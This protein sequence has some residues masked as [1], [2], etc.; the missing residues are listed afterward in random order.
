MNSWNTYV[1]EMKF[2][3]FRSSVD[4]ER[5]VLLDAGGGSVDGHVAGH[6]MVGGHREIELLKKCGAKQKDVCSRHQLSHAPVLPDAERIVSVRD[7]DLAVFN[8]P[9]WPEFLNVQLWV[10]VCPDA[11]V[12]RQPREAG[13]HHRVL[14]NQNAVSWRI[15]HQM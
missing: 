4:D 10:L 13:D 6:W 14:R 8:E 2:V 7:R 1:T 3:S 5:S 11:L 12:E 15:E 9:L